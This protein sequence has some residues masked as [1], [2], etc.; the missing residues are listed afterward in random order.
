MVNPPIRWEP[1]APQA[2]EELKGAMGVTTANKKRWGNHGHGW[3][4]LFDLRWFEMIWDHLRLV[5]AARLPKMFTCI[6][7][8]KFTNR[9]IIYMHILI[10]IY[11]YTCIVLI[12][13]ELRGTDAA[14]ESSWPFNHSPVSERARSSGV[15]QGEHLG[16]CQPLLS[17]QL[18]FRSGV[19]GL[20]VSSFWLLS[21]Q[22]VHVWHIC[23]AYMYGMYVWHLCMASVQI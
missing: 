9:Y 16:S 2:A 5:S 6:Y 10:Y 22:S 7:I 20:V 3:V 21:S 14:L 12:S 8:Y 17:T 15:R 1:P 18:R 4:G 23:M 19:N 11:I 13:L